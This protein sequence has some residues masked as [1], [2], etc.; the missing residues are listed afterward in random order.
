ML[1]Y[2]YPSRSPCSVWPLRAL[3]GLGSVEC[4]CDT[5]MPGG[6]GGVLESGE[7]QFFPPGTGWSGPFLSGVTLPLS[8]ILHR[9]KQDLMLGTSCSTYSI[10]FWA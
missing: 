8:F 6:G 7:S 1:S 9:E 4:W 10:L 3:P 2:F 5:T